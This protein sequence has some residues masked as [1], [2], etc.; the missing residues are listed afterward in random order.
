MATLL[1][2]KRAGYSDE[3]IALWYND[4]RLDLDQ[5]GYNRVE[6]SNYFGIPFQ[7]QVPTTDNLVGSANPEDTV[8]PENEN[9]NPKELKDAENTYTLAVDASSEKRKQKKLQEYEETIFNQTQD[10]I[11]NNDEIPYNFN[12]LEQNAFINRNLANL[13]KDTIIYD[14]R[15][16]P[17]DATYDTE[18]TLNE[19]FI[20]GYA[21]HTLRTL[22][23]IYG[24]V[25][26][27][28]D[29]YKM[30]SYVLDQVLKHYAKVLSG[31]ESWG[32]R[33]YSWGDGTY[34]MFRMTAEQVQTGINAYIDI[35][36]KGRVHSPAFPYWL[37]E[38][39]EDKD[40]SGI[41]ADAQ[42]ALFLAYL[43]QQEGF[44]EN[45]KGALT[46]DKGSVKK[47]FIESFLLPRNLD[48]SGLFKR[49]KEKEF[50]NIENRLLNNLKNHWL[51]KKAPVD[52]E[53]TSMQLPAFGKFMPDFISMSGDH[54][55]GEGRKD[56]WERG[57]MAS[58]TEMMWRLFW[59]LKEHQK[60]GK[61][62]DAV[63]L[64]EDF[65]TEGQRWDKRGMAGIR[66]I[67][68]DLIW[69]G[70]GGTVGAA[71]SVAATF[72]TGGLAAPLSPFIITGNAFALH[73]VLRHALIESYIQNEADTFEGFWNIILSDTS[74]K[75]WGKD[76]MLG[77][78]VAAGGIIAG[79]I[80]GPILSKVGLTTGNKIF[81]KKTGK[82]TDEYTKFGQ[83]LFNTSKVSG[84][85][86]MLATIP[87]VIAT[88]VD[89][90]EYL[91]PTKE[92]FLDAAV[93][94]FGLR[95]GLS[96]V[97][98]THP[99][100]IRGVKKLYRLYYQTGKSPKEILKDIERDES[101]LDDIQNDDVDMPHSYKVV[102][103]KIK[104]KF[105]EST[106]KGNENKIAHIPKPKFQ[107]GEEVNVD[108]TGNKKAKITKV[109]YENS[110]HF[111]IIDDGTGTTWRMA[112]SLL[113][114]HRER[115]DKNNVW[116]DKTKF[117]DKQSKG[118][119]DSKIDILQR[120]DQVYENNKFDINQATDFGNIM[121][122]FADKTE[123]AISNNQMLFIRKYYLKLT[124]VLKKQATKSDI[125]TLDFLVKQFIPKATNEVPIKFLFTIGK[126]NRLDTE[127][128]VIVGEARGR[129]FHFDL[130]QYMALRKLSDGTTTEVT[131]HLETTHS[132]YNTT[133]KRDTASA[134]L[135][136]RDGKHNLTGLLHSRV[137]NQKV[138]NEAAKFKQEFGT[139]EKEF[140][141]V[142]YT[143]IVRELPKWED[144]KMHKDTNVFRGFELYDLVKMFKEL[145]EGDTPTAK[146]FRRIKKFGYAAPFGKIRYRE[147]GK[148][149]IELNKDLMDAADKDYGKNLESIKMTM[150]HELGHYIDF[151]PD[152]TLARGNVLGRIASLKRY[153]NDWIAGKIRGE[154]PFTEVELAKFKR[155]AEK[156]ARAERN[157]NDKIIKDHGFDP[158]NVLKILT[159]AK[160][161]EYL[162]VAIYE[163]F[164]KASSD[165]KKAIIADALKGINNP[166]I[167]RVLSGKEKVSPISREKI[168]AIYY[169]ILRK[170]ARRRGLVARSEVLFELKKLTLFAK[171]IKYLGVN[172]KPEMDTK[173][174]A[175]EGLREFIEKYRFTP[176][177]LMADFMMGFLLRPRETENI[178]PITY[179]LWMNYMA[180]KSKVKEEWERIQIE[181]SLPEN[182]KQANILRDQAISYAKARQNMVE[183]A[184]RELDI[185]EAY[186]LTRRNFDSVWFTLFNYYR[187][188]T[189]KENW[190]FAKGESK[191]WQ[192]PQ[193]RFTNSER[194]NVEQAIE[195][196]MYG[197][198]LIES[199][200]NKLWQQVFVHMQDAG[201]SRD[202]FAAYLHNKWVG[203]VDGPRANVLNPK[204]VEVILANKLARQQEKTTPRIEEIAERFYRYREEVIMPLLEK[205]EV[206]DSAT[207]AL[208]RNNREYV[209]FVVEEYANWRNDS[210]VK[211]FVYHTKYGTAKDIMN[212]FE[213]T[214]LKDWQLITIAQRHFAVGVIS[215][216]LFKNKDRIENDLNRKELNWKH[217]FKLAGKYKILRPL[218]ER[219][220]EPAK[221]VIVGIGVNRTFKWIPK[222]KDLDLSKYALI[223]Y[224][225]LGET[226]AV[227]MGNEIAYGL[228]RMGAKKDFMSL[229][230]MYGLNA[231]YRKLFTELNPTFWS[232]NIFR[233]INR[234]VL[235]LPHTTY[236]DIRHG[237]KNAF[238]KQ[239]Y[240]AWR[241]TYR[242]MFKR[243][244]IQDKDIVDMLDKRLLISVYSKYRSAAE[245]MAEGT[246]TWAAVD[247]MARGIIFAMRK[248][249]WRKL[250]DAELEALF[251]KGFKEKRIKDLT[252]AER[253][254][255]PTLR[256]GLISKFE[257][258][259][260]TER[261]MNNDAAIPPLYKLIT[262]AEK[263]SRV[264]ERTTK[265]AAYR[266]LHKLKDDGII[267]WTDTQIDYAI[268]NW[269]G[270]PNFLRKGGAAALYNNILLF[271]NAAK[272]EW[273]SVLEAKQYQNQWVWWPKLFAYA[274]APQAIYWAA[275]L[276]A[277][278]TAAHLYFNLI[279][280][281]ILA[282]YYVVPLGM[283]TDAGE[284]EWGVPSDLAEREFNKLYKVVYLQF[285]KDEM[286][287]MVGA[288]VYHGYGQLFKEISDNPMDNTYENLLK[289]AIPALDANLPSLSPIFETL[290]NLTKITG[291]SNDP[292]KDAFSGIPIWPKR[293]QDATG[294]FG[295]G[296]RLLAYS[297]WLWNNSGGLM[298]YKFDTF[299]DPYNL[300]NIVLEVERKLGIPIFGKT[301]A[302]FLKISN[303]GVPE[304]VIKSL[305]EG[306]KSD[307]HYMAL[308]DHAV[309]KL[310]SDP[311][312]EL[313]GEEITA[314]VENKGW[315]VRWQN[316]IA[317]NYGT[318]FY[319]Y[320][321]NLEGD[322]FERAITK[323]ADISEEIG[324][325]FPFFKIGKSKE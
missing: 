9:L 13:D 308:A 97:N 124:D 81:N 26:V 6:Q 2:L 27:G 289:G 127:V 280:N 47:L 249:N 17:I 75:V 312:K 159:D 237:F 30:S 232:Y 82:S 301:V 155:E 136:F 180:K 91:P 110:E 12:G 267:D 320:L 129:M 144:I 209:T 290:I 161:R 302:R 255:A 245:G 33:S 137:P 257:T 178:A 41:T 53:N 50:R 229:Q 153:M 252:K 74:R 96:G 146:K 224:T 268:R 206:F 59:D 31:N 304:S 235:N 171:P 186:D 122:W 114:K 160:A 117:N 119:Y 197:D 272:E 141:D 259:M 18:F 131:I 116:V 286:L 213:A 270:S 70:L 177:E 251:K 158:K 316:A 295:F 93:I 216:W 107:I 99:V 23:H 191:N 200:Q 274:V 322:D 1:E 29:Q 109:G 104:D 243:A 205:S 185:S 138:T 176:P 15:G 14:D 66:S 317:S 238:L 211:S 282:N 311:P 43:S 175:D 89:K 170:E 212:P 221:K 71:Q 83:F 266:H 314:L 253:D 143:S 313:N 184:N 135:I 201:I 220:I 152:A 32:A 298:F 166:A 151:L 35:L 21:G 247:G 150:A 85:I 111:Y 189:D 303:R 273:R 192:K 123:Q 19:N 198:T 36:T 269:A 293:I 278:G 162:P 61:K 39:V 318:A 233:D 190:E 57:G 296:Q 254:L 98:K 217:G 182:V 164:A 188:I 261:W 288:G 77:A 112:E 294:F 279:G 94:I 149:T 291:W 65:L 148:G 84:E 285:P 287:K 310:M 258:Q 51:D 260:Y 297:K 56:A 321:V 140:A 234:T 40:I 58:A 179:K 125:D 223:E 120:D 228:K 183:K 194:W 163:A 239:V 156:T 174:I 78:G 248:P 64:I 60:T 277:M 145:S 134:V 133:G 240:K 265:L 167:L 5:A 210:W 306:R 73:G 244:E 208:I 25:G 147:G 172:I 11:M 118:E 319:R 219:T 49:L 222:D 121:S 103:K 276:G 325:E 72:V 92:D 250:S 262:D 87:S 22:E 126:D 187:K 193:S 55:M 44:T 256:D 204:G 202:I 203:K 4:K 76:F 132:K 275:K 307:N 67:A 38:L 139:Q 100:V 24:S 7:T 214:I 37:K 157:K 106:G 181:L 283:I 196:L 299:Y 292:P 86:T 215:R 315:L 236:L 226:K 46:G 281:D 102:E 168:D 52:I 10:A 3:E 169:E 34:G 218:I 225:Q 231:P 62:I 69:F 242:N 45:F 88:I 207:L 199:I 284:F 101:I 195:K 113:V 154:G 324:Y 241:P 68:Q 305:E 95:M 230:W 108:S 20:N 173:K 264:F 300:E 80:A 128:S 48:K 309:Y 227:Y 246:P 271:G 16:K 165:L 54:L 323:M 28:V 115:K 130:Q 263:L 42:V 105:N 142:E 90:Q 63:N 79:K 8:K